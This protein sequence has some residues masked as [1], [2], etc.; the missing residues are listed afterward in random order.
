MKNSIRGKRFA[1]LV[2]LITEVKLSI[3]SAASPLLPLEGEAYS[4]DLRAPRLFLEQIQK[5]LLYGKTF[6]PV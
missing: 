1:F 2:I 6:V 3:S 4:W 5:Y